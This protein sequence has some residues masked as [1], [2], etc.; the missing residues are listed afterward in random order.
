MGRCDTSL[1]KSEQ[2]KQQNEVSF[3][4]LLQEERRSLTNQ[5]TPQQGDRIAL[6]RLWALLINLIIIF[7]FHK[8]TV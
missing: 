5:R 6:Q 1:Y 2:T 3:Q 8:V 4:S 7:V